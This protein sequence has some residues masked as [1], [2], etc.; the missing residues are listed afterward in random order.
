METETPDE[1]T[2]IVVGAYP[3]QAELKAWAEDDIPEVPLMNCADAV[4]A[5]VNNMTM[6]IK[7]FF[8]IL[9]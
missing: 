2:F 6:E 3:I 4:N 7:Q 9:L 8:F 5:P 1:L